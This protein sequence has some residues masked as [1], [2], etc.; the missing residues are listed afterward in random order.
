MGLEWVCMW[1]SGSPRTGNVQG[2]LLFHGLSS[3]QIMGFLWL[4]APSGFGDSCCWEFLGDL[5]I[6]IAGEISGFGDFCG[7]SF[8]MHK[9][10][11]HHQVC[12]GDLGAV[13][14]AEAALGT[15]EGLLLPDLPGWFGAS[16]GWG[17]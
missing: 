9:G 7:Q 14:K 13:P 5:D 17:C 3:W 12:F 15:G 10:D 16:H 8:W 11:S 2:V 6:P 4:G 1:D